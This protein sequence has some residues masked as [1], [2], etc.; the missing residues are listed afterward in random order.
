MLLALYRWRSCSKFHVAFPKYP[1]NACER[2]HSQHLLCQSLALPL[3]LCCSY[4][5]LG[6]KKLKK[7]K[8]T[9]QK[10]GAVKMGEGR[11]SKWGLFPQNGLWA[12]HSSLS[13]FSML[14]C[15]QYQI[16]FLFAEFLCSPLRREQIPTGRR[17]S[18]LQLTLS[19][20]QSLLPIICTSAKPSQA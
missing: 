15:F 16:S 9:P 3:A 6:K 12:S 19:Y 11:E 13:G 10:L 14:I 20:S 7:K 17:H 2:K 4:N 8:D 18:H 1:K 5:M